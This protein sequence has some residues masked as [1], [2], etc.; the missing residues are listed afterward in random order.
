MWNATTW[1]KEPF[2]NSVRPGMGPTRQT[3][4]LEK[5]CVFVAGDKQTSDPRN[6]IKQEVG[7][8]YARNYYAERPA[9]KGGMRREI[10]D[11]IAWKDVTK[12]LEGRSKMFKMRYAK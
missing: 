9:S 8:K 7:G 12:A 5:A 10:F 6:A 11:T 2:T 3:L 1:Q 4:P